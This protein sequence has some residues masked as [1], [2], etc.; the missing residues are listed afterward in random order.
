MASKAASIL[1]KI[2][3]DA[4][5]FSKGIDQAKTD[6]EKL[7]AGFKSAV[8]PA[9]AILAGVTAGALLLR[10]A[11]EESIVSNSRLEQ[12]FRSMGDATGGAAKQA[13]AYAD[14]LMKQIGVDDETIK[15]AQAKL[16]TFGAVSDEAARQAGIFDRATA[17]AADLSAA[18][19]GDMSSNA[20]KL[21]KALQDP[22]KY[23]AALAKSGVVFTDQQKAQIKTLV[24]SGNTLDA[25]KIILSAVEEKVG[26]TAAATATSTAKQKVAW[27]ELQESLGGQ[28]LPMFDR[29]NAVM[30]DVFAWISSHLQLVITLA[31]VLA[32]VALAVIGV[33]A[34]MV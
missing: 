33:N 26:G 10:D 4:T 19:F 8:L 21:G 32:G 5:N 22:E 7:G 27:G 2:L 1:I 34:A 29:L 12:V 3:S 28:L 6:A 25:Q 17:A 30:M 11:A 31:A 9:T 23:L 24:E 20:T 13:E 18:G 15:E 14:V 16:A